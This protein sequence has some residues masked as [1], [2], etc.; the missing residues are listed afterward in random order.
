MKTSITGYL[1]KKVKVKYSSGKTYEGCVLE[2]S[3]AEDSDIGEESFTLAQSDKKYML[4][5]PTKGIVSI[6]HDTKFCEIDVM[7]DKA[8]S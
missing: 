3:F 4:E 6:I 8:F 5:L 1:G 2:Y 7:S